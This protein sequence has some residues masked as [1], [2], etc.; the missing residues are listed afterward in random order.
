MLRVVLGCGLQAMCDYSV[1]S[2]GE[3]EEPEVVGESLSHSEVRVVRCIIAAGHHCVCRE[4]RKM[5]SLVKR[6]ETVSLCL[7][8]ICLR[9]RVTVAM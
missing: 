9:G 2:D 4:R 5:E 1:D 8:A 7:M 3:W 6:R